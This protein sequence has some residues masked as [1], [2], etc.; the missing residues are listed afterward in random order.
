[1]VLAAMISA[2]VSA[3]AEVDRPSGVSASSDAIISVL[4]FMICFSFSL[5]GI[6]AGPAGG[7]AQLAWGCF[8]LKLPA[9]AADAACRAILAGDRARG[10]R[11][12][13]GLLRHCQ[14]EP[15]SAGSPR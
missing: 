11:E 12:R 10:L 3:L 13:S 7:K 4:R 6:G 14:Y 5:V 9:V 8:A 15:P 1:M 2:S